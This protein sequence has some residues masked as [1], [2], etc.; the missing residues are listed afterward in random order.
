MTGVQTCAL[1]DL[2]IAYGEATVDTPDL[3]LPHPRMLERAFVLVPL[4]EIVPDRAI[5]GVRIRD[6]LAKLDQT[7]IEKLSSR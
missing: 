3:T 1:P 2:L 6:A 5:A 4:V 7:G